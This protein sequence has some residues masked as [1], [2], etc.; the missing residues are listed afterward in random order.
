MWLNAVL[1]IKSE[2]RPNHC[3]SNTGAGF[4]A[5]LLLL[6]IL[7]YLPLYVAF[8]NICKQHYYK[9]CK[10]TSQNARG[11][12][13]SC[14]NAPSSAKHDGIQSSLNTCQNYYRIAWHNKFCEN[15]TK[16][17]PRYTSSHTPCVTL[18]TFVMKTDTSPK[19]PTYKQR[20]SRF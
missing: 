18:E 11:V 5:E 12:T 15:K 1:T 16:N 7:R 4:E 17:K 3:L 8:P 10:F 6:D 19:P 2:T 9:K 20:N 13:R 14:Q